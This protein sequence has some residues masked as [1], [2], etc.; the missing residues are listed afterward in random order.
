METVRVE[1]DS[2]ESI[3]ARASQLVGMTFRDVLALGIH[4]D[5]VARGAGGGLGPLSVWA[6]SATWV[7]PPVLW[8]CRNAEGKP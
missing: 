5:G 1:Y 3:R 2:E 4:P 6:S 7:V 8:V